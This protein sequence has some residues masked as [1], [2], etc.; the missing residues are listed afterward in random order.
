MEN[1]ALNDLHFLGSYV[2]TTYS[3]HFYARTLYVSWETFTKLQV[4][5]K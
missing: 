3:K 4:T 2:D 5:R 1:T